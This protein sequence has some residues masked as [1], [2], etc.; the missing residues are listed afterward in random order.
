MWFNIKP[1]ELTLP[2]RYHRRNSEQAISYR[3]FALHRPD[4]L[5]HCRRHLW[6]LKCRALVV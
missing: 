6:L 4:L 5:H 1:L 2:S 3:G